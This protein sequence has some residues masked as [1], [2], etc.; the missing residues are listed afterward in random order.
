MKKHI[1]AVQLLALNHDT[2]TVLLAKTPLLRNHGFLDAEDFT[3][4]HAYP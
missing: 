4:L 1:Q 3:V 2:D